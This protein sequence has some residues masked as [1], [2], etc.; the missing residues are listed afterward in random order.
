MLDPVLQYLSKDGPHALERLKQLLAIP[1]VSTDSAYA[2]HVAA[3]AG[4]V[5]NCMRSAGLDTHVHTTGGH[6]IVLGH[7]SEDDLP[8][9]VPHVLYYGHYDVQPPDPLDGWISPPFE[10]TVRDGAIYARGASD[11]KGQICCFLE[12]LRAWKEVHGK[13]PIRVTVLIEGEEECGSGHLQSFLESNSHE[14]EADVVLISDT[15]MW[16]QDT[17]AITY[18]LRGMLYYD[19][20]LHGP[21]RDLH[22]GMYGGVLANPATILTQVLGGL[23]DEKHQVTIPGFYDDVLPVDP[24]ERDEWN[25]LNFDE[26]GQCL[27]PV[28]VDRPFGEQGFSTLERKWARPACDIN[29]LYGGYG[30]E[31]AKT[32]IPSYAGAKVSFRLAPNQ[33]PSKI[34]VAFEAWLKSHDV[35]GLRWELTDLGEAMPVVVSHESPFIAA[36]QRAVENCTQRSAV[37]VREGATIPVVGQFKEL[38]DM[39]SLLIGFGLTDDAIHSPNE[40]FNLDCFSLGCRTHAA[41]IAELASLTM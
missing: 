33:D 4:F 11:D 31:G 25:N 38:L 9:D 5:D 29:G 14:L 19:V 16:D 6:P 15:T 27:S 37:L 3:A 2:E 13:L 26:M 17:V 32:I 7:N 21:K 40:K 39:D 30:G 36:A 24:A 1:S 10:P 28:G 18:G 22:S 23:F 8:D 35:H 41:L 34:A 20:K 12:A